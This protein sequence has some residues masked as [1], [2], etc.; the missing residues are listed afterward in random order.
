MQQP[1][2]SDVLLGYSDQRKI[3]MKHQAVVAL[4]SG[5]RI[6]GF[7]FTAVRQRLID[8]LNDQREFIPFETET[9]DVLIVAKKNIEF[10]K[11]DDKRGSRP[12]S[13]QS[14]YDVLGLMPGVSYAEVRSAYRELANRNNP[15]TLKQAGATEA[16][17][18]QAMDL[19][20][21]VKVAFGEITREFQ[22]RVA[23]P[24]TES[25]H[26]APPTSQT[27]PL[28]R[29]SDGSAYPRRGGE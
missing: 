25:M 18:K 11:D 27:R 22:N 24:P 19:F 23:P 9:G 8:L 17:I 14:P 10:V 16:T 12:S 4:S 1:S 15:E 2:G 28:T 3:K 21:K 29:P 13:Y 26:A 20:E 7:L 6:S 5:E